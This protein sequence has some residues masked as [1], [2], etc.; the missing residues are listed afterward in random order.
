[1]HTWGPTR[2]R[3]MGRGEGARSRARKWLRL[4]GFNRVFGKCSWLWAGPLALSGGTDSVMHQWQVDG[5][6]ITTPKAD[7]PK[8]S[9]HS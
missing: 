9:Q 6:G 7:V 1:M 5:S 2:A 3:E 8:A 4:S